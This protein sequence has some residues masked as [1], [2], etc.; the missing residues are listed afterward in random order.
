MGEVF[1]RYKDGRFLGFYLRW[2]EGGKRR[3]RASRQASHAE[4]RRM[5]QAI[6][7][8]IA[9]GL[10]G[11]DEPSA[12]PAAALTLAALIER[13]L[14]EYRRP[15]MKDAASYRAYAKVALQRILPFLGSEPAHRIKSAQV[16]RLADALSRKYAPA[17]VR[18]SLAFL[19]TVYSWAIKQALLE[20][21]PCRGVE[22]PAG[23]RMLE[24]LSREE[25]LR[26]L[27]YT[28]E[29]A[30]DRHPAIAAALYLGLRKG[31]L[32]GLR[33]SDLD[34]ECRRISVSRSYS[35]LPKGGQARHLRIP[36]ELLPIL[37]EWRL[38]CPAT[39][40]GLVFPIPSR[41]TSGMGSSQTML[42]LAEL[43]R[44]AGCP[45]LERPMHALRHTF[46]SHFIMA[47]GNILSL[48][49][50]LGHSDVKMTLIY[51]HLAPDF[52]GDEMERI[53]FRS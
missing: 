6:E 34:L 43:L 10:A 5:L 19:H 32:F 12:P 47:G 3:V 7:G 8:R 15:R 41:G 25:A 26:L 48:Q 31:E 1:K 4:A 30:P 36:A 50:I 23:R 42:G 40:E 13:F 27:S 22:R 14:L 39:A 45:A 18:V 24:Y 49:K 33:W 44:R 2:Y 16:S 29:H 35:G 53:R 52:L 17:S 38:R 21:N 37:R 9:R 46:A 20:S 28:A 51:A 11:L